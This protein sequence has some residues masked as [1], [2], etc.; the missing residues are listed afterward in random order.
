MRL[1]AVLVTLLIVGLLAQRQLGGGN[2]EYPDAAVESSR[3]GAPR[4][5]TS[6]GQVQ[7]FEQQIN[8]YVGDEAARRAREMEAAERH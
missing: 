7:S 3:E 5:P 6:P 2:T 4:V 1:I 8:E